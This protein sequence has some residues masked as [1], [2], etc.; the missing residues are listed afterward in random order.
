MAL[1]Q[2]KISKSTQT[3]N[4]LDFEF[5]RKQGI[6]YI[7]ALGSA[8]WTDF[9]TH[10]PGITI[11][12]ILCYAITDLGLRLHMPV[13]DLLHDPEGKRQFFEAHEILPNQALTALDYRKLLIDVDPL[14]IHN[15][16]LRPYQPALYIN[17]REG[18]VSL[19]PTSVENIPSTLVKKTGIQGLYTLWLDLAD[20]ISNTKPI[21]EAV[22][23][24][25]H[26]NRNLC[27]DIAEVQLVK[28]EKIRVCA[29][30]ELAPQADEHQIYAQ[31]L[32]LID[33]YFSPKVQFYS[34]K[35]LL[36]SG[37]R[38]EDIFK[39]PILTH[40]F[41]KDEELRR[42][43]LRSEVRLSDLMNVILSIEGVLLIEDM[44][45]SYCQGNQV[46]DD[47]WNLC[48]KP[49]HKPS[50]CE[51]KSVFS[52][53]KEGLAITIDQAK[54]KVHQERLSSKQPIDLGASATNKTLEFPGSDSFPI[55]RYHS[56]THNFPEN[57]GIGHV[58]LS[59]QETPTRLAQAK[60][61]KAYLL[62]FDQILASYFK[63]LSQVKEQ[64][65]VDGTLGK[66]YFS[67]VIGEMKG[68][69]ELF[70]DFEQYS[71]YDFFAQLDN[72]DRRVTAIKNHLIARFAENFGNY[73]FL[74]KG[75][76][77]DAAASIV[78]RN[79][80]AFLRN[81]D[82]ISSMRAAAMNYFKQSEA[83][84][85]NT[86]NV[87]GLENRIAALLGIKLS[88]DKAY[89]RTS[90]ATKFA[91]V[92]YA[93]ATEFRWRIRNAE[94]QI[95]LTA[96][97]NYTTVEAAEQE[98][99]Q[100]I[101]KAIN[102]N[103]QAIEN[104]RNTNFRRRKSVHVIEIVKSENAE[105][106]FNIINPAIRSLQDPKRIIA[107]QFRLFQTIEEVKQAVFDLIDFLMNQFTDE[108][109]H[110][111]EHILLLPNASNQSNPAYYFPICK[112]DCDAPCTADPYSFRLSI[113]LPGY[114]QR[115]S[116]LN[117]RAFAEDVIRREIPA[118]ILAKICW[119]GCGKNTVDDSDNDLLQL[120]EN[121]RKFLI[122]KA[123]GKQ[124]SIPA[125]IQAIQQLK[126]IYPSGQL[127]DCASSST[128]GKIILGRTNL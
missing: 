40:G 83:N 113:V 50:L 64:L 48:I 53:T 6:E 23:Q 44:S 94:N 41:I 104:I 8:L 112:E 103:R 126:N 69:G 79:K 54:V 7:E 34:L 55:D 24:R 91:K 11:L 33:E 114:T 60:Q 85:W 102:T 10:D 65:S 28:P 4:D 2:S 99:Y 46:V 93:N 27:E 127:H 115:F 92:Y 73:A 30:L 75:V 81:Y 67:Q 78:S 70:K 49:N 39:G 74:M 63:H 84:L 123:A 42:K 52:F 62:F 121:L 19:D 82:R 68:I 1:S 108:G 18:A 56:V 35:E 29:A 15:C 77:G 96:T 38:A 17:C 21:E 109:I 3:K 71:T 12:E 36:D 95:V 59:D 13:Q 98:M 97:E 87:S 26:A 5:L 43:Q 100:S 25:Y 111:I 51:D 128:E 105:F 14:R 116:D 118:H 57:Y 86:S 119:V 107:R 120:E 106:S 89:Q 61:L 58:G 122:D 88:E 124:T 76:Y 72:D 16:F 20:G 101:F 31:V 47:E 66:S 125:L 117:F 22:L 45:I 90:I 37:K 32:S 110:V 80:H 9:N